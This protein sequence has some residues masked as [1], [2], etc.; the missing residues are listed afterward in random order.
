MMKIL[1]IDDEPIT[2]ET[3][4]RVLRSEFDSEVFLLS[5]YR[6]LDL[7]LSNDFDGIVLDLMMP[8]DDSFFESQRLSQTNEFYVGLDLF[9][10]IRKKHPQIPVV[11]YTSSSRRIACDE[12]SMIL[13]KPILAKSAAKSIVDH[14]KKCKSLNVLKEKC[15]R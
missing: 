13:N 3:L 10:W 4:A 11:F 6:R 14:I 2:C 12:Y 7:H 8:Y 1:I 9:D 5:N 15:Q